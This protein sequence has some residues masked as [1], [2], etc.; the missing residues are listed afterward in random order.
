M[1]KTEQGREAAER[2]ARAVASGEETVAAWVTSGHEVFFSLIPE[3]LNNAAAALGNRSALSKWIGV[4]R[5]QTTRWAHGETRPSPEAERAIT[6][7]DFIV[8]RARMVWADDVVP[9][10]LHG[11]NAFLGG[12]TP[13]EM[14]RRGRTVE[15]LEAISAESAGTYG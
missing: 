1:A 5:S 11:H 7:L 2:S 15:V 8:A 10:W 9:D 12:S 14:I 3:K 13:L 4:S 6:D